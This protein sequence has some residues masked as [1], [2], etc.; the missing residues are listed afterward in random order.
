M[1]FQCVILKFLLFSSIV[2]GVGI[3]ENII[4]KSKSIMVAI[5]LKCMDYQGNI[6]GF[7]FGRQI[8]FKNDII[9]SHVKIEIKFNPT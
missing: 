7:F 8:F 2:F 3:S 4:R 1:Q 5:D 6:I 9:E